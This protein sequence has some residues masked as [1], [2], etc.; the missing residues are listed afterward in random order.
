MQTSS[1]ELVLRAQQS[2]AFMT[3]FMTSGVY[4][5]RPHM[6]I[7]AFASVP[8]LLDDEYS[9]R[10]CDT[11]DG[12]W[13]YFQPNLIAK[14]IE[15]VLR[16]TQTYERQV[17]YE[18]VS[19]SVQP[20]CMDALEEDRIVVKFVRHHEF[21]ES[22]AIDAYA[23]SSCAS[24]LPVEL[25]YGAHRM[26][27]P[28]IALTQVPQ[29]RSCAFDV[30]IWVPRAEIHV[31]SSL[32]GTP[33]LGAV[34]IADGGAGRTASN[35]CPS[36]STWLPPPVTL[37]PPLPSVPPPP[38]PSVPSRPPPVPPTPPSPPPP[39]VVRGLQDEEDGWWVWIV[40]SLSSLVLCM[41]IGI[42]G[43]CVVFD[44]GRLKRRFLAGRLPAGAR[45]TA[46]PM[47]ESRS[48]STRM[49]MRS[50]I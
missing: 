50:R 32:C 7:D 42:C 46:A 5:A 23:R 21:A 6:T 16:N 4:L 38:P 30:H 36:K 35:V 28:T 44:E 37:P 43:Y 27:R 48:S 39:P 1:R 25:Q 47:R 33:F 12:V 34:R 2:Q 17:K 45:L 40:A 26:L 8:A 19:S 11:D 15:I 20:T 22:S 29:E 41:F 49:Q 9:A 24:I 18:F 14:R 13:I 31:K 3:R 10:V